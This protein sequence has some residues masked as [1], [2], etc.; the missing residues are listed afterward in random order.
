MKNMFKREAEC[1]V[2]LGSHSSLI[3]FF[4]HNLLQFFYRAHPQTNSL[5]RS[6]AR[7]ENRFSSSFWQSVIEM[8]LGHFW[9]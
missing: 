5:T 6:P 9:C 4:E 7:Y 8:F 1:E 2:T 3:G